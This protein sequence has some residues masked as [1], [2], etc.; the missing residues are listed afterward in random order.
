MKTIEEKRT[1]ALRVIQ[2]SA[3][4]L[5]VLL[6]TM[7][8]CGQAEPEPEPEQYYEPTDYRTITLRNDGYIYVYYKIYLN[9]EGVYPKFMFGILENGMEPVTFSIVAEKTTD[10][11]CYGAIASETGKTWGLVL[12]EISKCIKCC[13][14]YGVPDIYVVF[15]IQEE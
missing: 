5:T 3:I 2:K 6:I 9:G 14:T 13:S 10:M 1:R 12:W 4:M 8:G 15:D 7:V 11:F